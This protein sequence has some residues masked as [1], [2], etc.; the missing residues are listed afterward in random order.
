MDKK[1]TIAPINGV[2]IENT[3]KA[4][5]LIET[6]YEAKKLAGYNPSS[7]LN[8]SLKTALNEA[9]NNSDALC[10][11]I[12]RRLD[13]WK[14]LL[15]HYYKMTVRKKTEWG[16]HKSISY[17]YPYQVIYENSTLWVLEVRPDDDYNGGVND[18]NYTLDTKFDYEV[19]LEEVTEEEFRKQAELSTK[20]VINRR[21][22]REEDKRTN[23]S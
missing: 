23:K 19:T 3:R 22:K 20:H 21:L 4:Y 12:Q 15:C 1:I 8:K 7:E 13:I 14:G 17:I 18:K 5:D 9:R 2:E 6:L 16:E 10:T 11:A